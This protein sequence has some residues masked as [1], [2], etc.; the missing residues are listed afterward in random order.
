M[1]LS[2]AFSAVLL[3]AG[4]L[5]CVA[6]LSGFAQS[7]SI[8]DLNG[9]WV[10]SGNGVL[11]PNFAD[12]LGSELPFTEYGR[13]RYMNFDHALNTGARC[14]P[15]GPTRTWQVNLPFQI[16]QTP[17]AVAILYEI[18]RT[19]RVI[20]T[21]NREH[22]EIVFDYPEWMGHSVG[23]YEGDTLVVET[24]GINPR[25]DIDN[26]GHEHSDQLRLE[27][28]IRK[29]SEDTLDWEVTVHDPVFFTEPFTV[30]KT[31][32]LLENDRVMDYTCQENE[33]DADHLVPGVVI[34]PQ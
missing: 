16:M 5:L 23:H 32:N 15:L 4:I 24:V 12:Q 7:E 20:Y 34:G 25:A 8:P 33:R 14:L 2:R 3:A 28:R 9:V 10:G 30:S 31:F 13:E 29:T 1:K 19:F 11:S 18:R 26:I 17:E 27:E 6:P 21:D 22:P